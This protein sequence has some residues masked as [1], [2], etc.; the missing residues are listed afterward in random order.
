MGAPTASSVAAL[1]IGLENAPLVVVQVVVVADSPLVLGL[2]VATVVGTA[3]EEIVTLAIVIWMIGMTVGAM[4]T[5]TGLTAVREVM[6]GGT[7]MLVINICLVGI[8]FRVVVGVT[9]MDHQIDTHRMDMAETGDM[10]GKQA[11][12][13]VVTGIVLEGLPVMMEVASGI[14]QGPMT[15]LAGEAD[16]HPMSAIEDSGWYSEDS[17]MLMTL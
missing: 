8:D 2:V 13:V 12:G 5:E 6:V 4:E 14:G 11:Q 9:V 10:T 15:A 17:G 3:L 16:H 7:A 1:D